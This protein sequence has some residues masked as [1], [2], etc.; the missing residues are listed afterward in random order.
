MLPPASGLAGNPAAAGKALPLGVSLRPREAGRPLSVWPRPSKKFE[1]DREEETSSRPGDLSAGGAPAP[2]RDKGQTRTARTGVGPR[3]LGESEGAQ[4]GKRRVPRRPR[5]AYSRAACSP[6]L[7]ERSGSVAK[8]VPI[9][10][11]VAGLCPRVHR[12]LSS[13]HRHPRGFK[14]WRAA[15][16]PRTSPGRR[17]HPPLPPPPPGPAPRGDL[18]PTAPSE[19]GEPVAEAGER[20]FPLPPGTCSTGGTRRLFGFVVRNT[21]YF[22]LAQATLHHTRVQNI[23]F[24][25]TALSLAV[26]AFFLLS[27]R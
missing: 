13:P 8:M 24:F 5:P 20:S 26:K 14:R 6:F 21:V 15:P 19:W 11:V 10:C 7:G 1:Q 4:Q 12:L 2:S 3:G 23:N 18:I 9:F 17:S 16:G 25:F 27:I 22:F